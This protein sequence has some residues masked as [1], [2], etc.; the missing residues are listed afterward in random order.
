MAKRQE[1]PPSDERRCSFCNRDEDTIHRL[2]AGPEGVF[3]CNECVDLCRDILDGEGARP[4]GGLSGSGKPSLSPQE[5]FCNL[6]EYV[7]GQ[8]LAKRVLSVAVYN[9]YKRI[10]NR[11]HA[12]VELEKANILLVGPTGSGKTLL[13]QTLARSLDVPFCIADATAL[14]EAGYVGEDV[15][16]I[17]LR[18]L[19]ASDFNVGRAERGIVYIDEIDK[20]ARK[21][22]DNPSIT[23]DVS[24]EGVQQALLK[25]IEGAVVNV[26]PQGGRKHPQQEFIQVDTTDILFICGGT[27]D[28]LAEIVAERVGRRGQLGFAGT[29]I[30][31]NARNADESA[32]LRMITPDDLMHFGMIPE[33]V[34]RLPVA[35]SV[36][37]LD[38]AALRA[39][40]TEPR[41]ALVKQYQRLF[42]MVQVELQ[43]EEEAL[44]AAARLAMQRETGARGLRS[45][46]EGALLD[47]MYDIPSRPDIRSVVVTEASILRTSR[48]LLFDEK[49]K[50]LNI[51]DES[52]PDA[53]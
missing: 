18:L 11:G 53:A 3:I 32:L 46:I 30:D 48:P 44:Q 35:T 17:L 51:G 41:N 22:G 49:N 50:Q 29:V 25:I 20:T 5:I 31:P 36:D 15:E 12:E 19:Q 33:L 38:E 45:T 2:I 7:V 34:G 37:A 23:R 8:S 13:A 14:T 6:E 16:N 26:P 40:L 24:G 47:V 43:F 27:F 42:E 28:G 4:A 21:S 9:H 52:L 10:A 39:I 1:N